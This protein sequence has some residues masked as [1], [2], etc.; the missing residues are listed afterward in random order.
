V[1]DKPANPDRL[2]ARIAA[3]QHGL[4]TTAQLERAGLGRRGASARERKGL[5]HRIHRGVYGVGCAALSYHGRWL[6][7]VLACG[8]GA[9]LSHI[10]AAQLWGLVP[11]RQGPVHVTVPTASGRSRRRGI[12]LHRSPSLPP[13]ATA[14]LDGIAVTTVARTLADLRRTVAPAVYRSAVRQAEF[15]G[16]DLGPVATDGT[17]SELERKLLAICRRYRLPAAEVNVLVGPYTVDFLWRE[18]RLVVEVDG[19]GAHRGRQA[20]EDDRERDRRLALLGYRVL[21]FT[22]RQVTED[23]AGVADAIRA[24]LA[25]S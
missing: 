25:P 9:V 7:A 8:P 20:F 12:R 23:T 22:Y 11:A 16:Y 18:S 2:I 5:L 13:A 3:R 10:S 1:E 6:A 14:S 17:R 21:R 19:Y 15:R 24:A 4:V